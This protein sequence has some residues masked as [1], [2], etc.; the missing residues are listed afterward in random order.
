MAT[1]DPD[2]FQRLAA[3]TCE[4]GG[5]AHC[6]LNTFLML[7]CMAVFV[8]MA[9]FVF[10]WFEADTAEDSAIAAE[11]AQLAADPAS[12]RS[13]KFATWK[14][15]LASSLTR[16]RRRGQGAEDRAHARF[17]QS[18]VLSVVQAVCCLGIAL[19]AMMQLI[20]QGSG[21]ISGVDVYN[22]TFAWALCS[23]A[24]WLANG[25]AVLLRGWRREGVPDYLQAWC[26]MLLNLHTL[27]H[28]SV[29]FLRRLLAFG[30]E[31]SVCSSRVPWPSFRRGARML[32]ARFCMFV[33]R[34]VVEM[35]DSLHS[36]RRLPGFWLGIRRSESRATRIARAV[37]NH[38][39]LLSAGGSSLGSC[40]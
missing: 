11:A 13:R 10:Q 34:F 18:T 2:L 15:W 4:G 36:C 33:G 28:G 32:W 14:P 40:H 19:S 23:F 8:F 5:H 3:A 6:I 30:G 27:P 37:L 25:V 39:R 1:S 35:V 12:S 7:P 17:V 24:G 21:E 20:F 29:V 26:G 22:G 9:P 31:I 16:G 38:A